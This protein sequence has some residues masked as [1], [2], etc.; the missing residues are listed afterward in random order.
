MIYADILSMMDL[1][2]LTSVVDNKREI[3]KLKKLLNFDYENVPI[4]SD[5]ES[6][7]LNKASVYSSPSQGPHTLRQERT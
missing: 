5:V 7:E 1:I 3:M 4:Q 2:L 6:L